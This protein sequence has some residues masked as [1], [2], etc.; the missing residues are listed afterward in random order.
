MVWS[1]FDEKGHE[2]KAKNFSNGKTQEDIVNEV[3]ELIKK[4]TKIV[5]IHGKCGTGK[6]AIALNIAK[7][8]GRA[9]I[10]VPIKNLQRQYQNDYTNK[11]YVLKPN[12]EKLGISVITGRKNHV[13]PYLEENRKDI[14][15]TKLKEKNANIYDI[16]QDFKKTT[17]SYDKDVSCD[18]FLI[19]CKI[20][21]KTKN[22]S[23]LKKYY[24]ENP[25]RKTSA[26]SEMDLK[27]MKRFA[28]APA[29]PYWLPVLNAEM[30]IKL[31]C[32][33][34]KYKSIAGEHIIYM[35]KTGC[36]YYNQ[37]LAYADSD[38]IIFNSDS[39]LLE[40]AIGRKPLTD[41]EIIDECDEFLDNF[42][43]EGTINL[44]KLMN[45]LN[46][47]YTNE[48]SEKKL[49]E[50][51]GDDVADLIDE[52]H[53]Y[54]GDPDK[55]IEVGKTKAVELIKSLVKSD[56]FEIMSDESYLEHCVEIARKFY[57]ILDFT[58]VNF[59]K[60]KKRDNSDKTDIYL[61]FVTINLE[62]LLDDLIDKNKA[63]VFMSGTLHSKRVLEEVFGLKNFK[64][65]DAETFNQGTIT[66][67]KTGL[68]QDFKFENFQNGQVTRKEYLLALDRCVQVSK[69]PSIVQVSAFQDLPS[70]EEKMKYNLRELMTREDLL[71][72]QR[73][74]KDGKLVKEFKAGKIPI[75]F[76][77]KCNRGIDFPFETCNS[78]IIT[79]FPYPNTQ[80]LFWKILKKN[81][82]NI[83]W[84]FY[85]DKAHRE[86]L[87]RIYRSVRAPEDHVYLLS[88]DIRVLESKVIEKKF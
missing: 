62:K 15:A 85:K 1:L 3:V 58:Y 60:E 17:E 49:I 70:A 59:S 61:K 19:P 68:E 20:E 57:E 77:T 24:S 38:V 76:T 6:S 56:I 69:I 54:L 72:Q 63:F 41:V 2:L 71:E 4:G 75:M 16:F 32:E 13:C 64:V 80:S 7:D 27:T 53:K 34:K 33:K 74:D 5:F 78:V 48:D 67:I 50:A 44:S 30:N 39:Y 29:C 37:F 25:E 26:D 28:V 31:E 40:S 79:K 42:A 43:L 12:G 10:I 18:N 11:K 65:V 86:L 82:P 66:N 46:G 8:L 45:E 21:I 88:P 23:T 84:D 52:S 47:I 87:Q 73:V 35:R 22:I 81:K 9:S 55:V 36:P 51:L 83:F 14:M